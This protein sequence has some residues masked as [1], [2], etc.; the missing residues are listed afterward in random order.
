MREPSMFV[1][2]WKFVKVLFLAGIPLCHE[3]KNARTIPG[4]LTGGGF[5]LHPPAVYASMESEIHKLRAARYMMAENRKIFEKN[6]TVRYQN[7]RINP[8]I[9]EEVMQSLAF[10]RFAQDLIHK[11]NQVRHTPCLT[12]RRLTRCLKAQSTRQIIEILA[13]HGIPA[14]NITSILNANL[15][16]HHKLLPRDIEAY[17]SYYWDEFYSFRD[18]FDY[19]NLNPLN[20]NYSCHREALMMPVDEL[21][22]GLGIVDD[23]TAPWLN[24]K[25]YGLVAVHIVNALRKGI[26]LRKDIVKLY[27]KLD[28]LMDK[29]L[30]G[31]DQREKYM[32]IMDELFAS[33]DFSGQKRLTLDEVLAHN[34]ALEQGLAGKPADGTDPGHC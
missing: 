32:K 8:Y 13:M 34:R 11:H 22:T 19:L 6:L 28:K 18:A 24:K 4:I 2:H 9:D 17:T 7:Q 33:I 12:T 1:P 29:I 5:N 14:R 27:I 25:I 30:A 26:G 21:M 10:P 23:E 15:A 31:N 3:N 16:G 20:S